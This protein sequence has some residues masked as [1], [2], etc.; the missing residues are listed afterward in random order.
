MMDEKIYNT[1]IKHLFDGCEKQIIPL[2]FRENVYNDPLVIEVAA[3][4]KIRFSFK[5]KK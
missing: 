4:G 5:F 1:F 2:G 3:A